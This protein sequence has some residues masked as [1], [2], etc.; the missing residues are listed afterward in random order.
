MKQDLKRDEDYVLLPPGVWDLLYELYGGGPALPRMVNVPESNIVS[1]TK[2]HGTVRD[3]FGAFLD[4]ELNTIE[5]S[6]DRIANMRAVRVPEVLSVVTHPWILHVLL[7]DP[8]QPYRRGESGPMSIRVMAHP[9]QPLWR[10]FAEIVC[11]FPLQSY[12]AYDSDKLGMARLWKKSTPTRTAAAGTNSIQQPRYGPWNLLCKN[13]HATLHLMSKGCHLEDNYDEVVADWKQYTD[14]NSVES[15]GLLDNDTVLL[16]FAV[17]NK[18]GD[19]TWPREAAA[20]AGQVQRLA[21]E[22]LIFR[23]TLQGVDSDD[24]PLPNPPTL[25]GMEVDAQDSSGKWYTVKIIEV[26]TKKEGDDTD[27]NDSLS[28]ED[29]KQ[30][31]TSKKQVKVHFR[32]HGGYVEWIDVDSDQLQTAGRCAS[33][34]QDQDS[35]S[36]A[37]GN[38]S[39]PVG[40]GRSKSSASAKRANSNTAENPADNTKSCPLPGLGACGLTN[41]GNTCYMN[42]A[43]QC[44][45]YLP[46]L[47]AYIL[48]SQYKLTGDLNKDNPLGTGGKLLEE[49]A[50]L[51]R[52]VWSARFAEKSPSR[53]RTQ[54]AKTNSQFSGADQQDAQEFLNYII[55][56]LHEDSNKVR[57]KPY[58]EAL[59]DEWVEKTYL[60]RVGEEAWRRFLRRN[61]SIMA[62]VTMGQALNTVTCPVCNHKS[63]SFD[64]F[65]LLSIPIPTGSDIIF[66]CTVIRRGSALNCP[67]IL[68]QTRQESRKG[69]DRLNCLVDLSSHYQRNPSTPSPTNIAEQYVIS[70]S[71]LADVG[72][73]RLQIQNLSGIRANR[74]RLCRAEEIVTEIETD[75][76]SELQRQTKVI[77]LTD[78][79]GPASHYIKK[80]GPS[81]DTPSFPTQIIAFELTLNPRDI[82]IDTPVE[83]QSYDR[84]N[85]TN[86]EDSYSPGQVTEIERYLSVYGD[87]KECRL[88]DTD[89]AVLSEAVSRSMWPRSDSD[90][91]IGLRVDAKDH[92][93]NWFVGSVVDVYEEEITKK[94]ADTG[95]PIREKQKKVRVHFDNFLPKWDEKYSFDHFQKDRVAPLYTK[96]EAN[97]KPTELMVHHRLYDQ[98]R[99]KMFIFGQS[100]YIQCHSEW[101]NARAGAHILA[102]VSRF[103]P[104]SASNDFSEN[105][106]EVY[107]L[108]SDLIDLFIDYDRKF[109]QMA[110][111][112]S[113]NGKEIRSGHNYCNPNFVPDPLF[114]ELDETV[115]GLLRQ[116]PFELR[117]CT[118]D[119]N[120]DKINGFSDDVAFPF[121]LN[122]TIGNF[123]SARSTVVVHWRD[124]PKFKSS[125]EKVAILYVQPEVHIHEASKEILKL[126]DSNPENSKK[127]AVG[128]NEV[129]LSFCLNEFCKV[130]KLP[131]SD[132]WQCPRCMVIREGGQKMNLW[133]LPDLLTFHVK[134]FN[135]SA[136]WH[137]KITTRVN[138]PLT[139]LDMS[140]WCHNDSPVL[141]G[142]PAE[143]HIYDLIAV[144]NHYGGL[145]GG[146][147]VATC[148]A[149]LCGKDGHEE[150]AY[151]FNGAGMEI[152][153]IDDCPDEPSGWFQVRSKSD[154]NRVKVAAAIYSKTVACSAEPL[155]L[156]FDDDVV[157]A[158]PPKQVI[159]EMAYVLFYRRRCMTA[160]NIAKY[161]TLE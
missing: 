104:R 93:G 148:K 37:I 110:L 94:D 85:V 157:E 72:D 146:H 66:Q 122:R 142:D 75:N 12:R 17:Q 27:D 31:L 7:C 138:F 109:V 36:P 139:G 152:S 134:R 120:S 9:N 126:A 97:Y 57:Q 60:P 145:T 29:G 101:S 160:S 54:L 127:S 86:K 33:E 102:Q 105:M 119:T 156:Q 50:D 133:R 95:E 70:L 141:K 82:M 150:V 108:I 80:H 84:R 26:R 135:M 11:R 107:N 77:P 3:S 143:S 130:Q 28:Q 45:G 65:N 132:N 52:A 14:N 41:L 155:W 61:R 140:Q 49:L 35:F 131:I 55:D 68:N 67:W 30:Q 99:K 81:E 92:R 151:S 39:S 118:V 25:V 114:S 78:K 144:M 88:V 128:S 19:L 112:V 111:G 116:L 48:S 158:I 106:S 125:N 154:V 69:N 59:E 124:V 117:V 21:Q 98:T 76:G 43:L 56:V 53:F 40:E 44:L 47:R 22:D 121:V 46:L 100:F 153:E 71:R 58:V 87:E 74:L 5:I 1:V 64:P 34:M 13:R 4:E 51:Q 91:K 63:R 20:K 89:V 115:H 23:Q 159:S 8:V 32:D 147:Y 123:V 38:G 42:S 149:T 79:E 96:A 10:V 24:N 15:I 73:L 113:Q 137:E 62:D 161:S 136:R 90:F 129:D 83:N 2:D 18:N 6:M 16:E 103:L